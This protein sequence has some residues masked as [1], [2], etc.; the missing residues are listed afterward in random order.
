MNLE[1]ISSFGGTIGGGFVGGILIGYALKKIVKLVVIGLFSVSLA[2]LQYQQIID[3]KLPKLQAVSQKPFQHL[4]M[5]PLR[6]PEIIQ[7]PYQILVYL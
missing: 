3:I 2:S 4:Q 1:S 6:F 5:R 7:Q